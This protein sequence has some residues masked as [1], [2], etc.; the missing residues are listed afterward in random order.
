LS[1]LIV[2][3][4]PLFPPIAIGL[5]FVALFALRPPRNGKVV[6]IDEFARLSDD[7]VK[8][9]IDQAIEAKQRKDLM[10]AGWLYEQGKLWVKAAE[11]YQEA[12]DDLWA[13]E[14]FRRGGDHRRSGEIYRLG[15]FA[16]EAATTLEQGGHL[17]DAG[18]NYAISGDLPRAARLFEQASRPEEAAELYFRLGMFHQAGKL[19]EKA[20]E[21]GRAADAYER[22]LE[23]LG[24]K[25]LEADIRIARVLEKEGREIATIRFLEAVGEVMAAL[26]T[27]I[28]FSHDDEALRLYREYREIL[29]APLLKGAKEGKLSATVLSDLFDRAG[30][31]V[32]AARMA[33]L[34]GQWRRVAELYEKAGK[35][36]KAAAAWKEAGEIGEAALAFER[37]GRFGRAA[38]LFEE[39]GEPVRALHCY[40]QADLHYEAGLLYER[41]GEPEN[42]ITS[43]QSVL[44]DDSNWRDARLRLGALFAL[45]GRSELALD[46]YEDV[47]S[48]EEPGTSDV[49]SLVVM[50]TLLR[51]R[52][53]YGEAAACFSTIAR[54]DASRE[55]IEAQMQDARLRAEKG[56]QEVPVHFPYEPPA[57]PQPDAGQTFERL[58][59][60]ESMAI[61]G[62]FPTDAPGPSM[63]SLPA[64]VTA[65]PLPHRDVADESGYGSVDTEDR[66][67]DDSQAD[68]VPKDTLVSFEAF[69]DGY[70]DESLADPATSAELES[71][72]GQP[73]ADRVTGASGDSMESDWS[74][75]SPEG[76]GLTQADID[77]P[78]AW[79]A[80]DGEWAIDGDE[81]EM[82]W[83]APGPVGGADPAEEPEAA[84]DPDSDE[85]VSG[86]LDSVEFG[87]ETAPSGSPLESFEVFGI[88]DKRERFFVERFFTFIEVGKGED[89]L[90]GDEEEDGLVLLVAGDAEV[91]AAGGEP[92]RFSAPALLGPELLLKG[93]LPDVRITA[94]ST[95]QCWTLSRAAARR[96]AEKDRDVALRLARALRSA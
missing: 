49:D 85:F 70:S 10:R 22:M 48:R 79:E 52:G 40:R 62:P 27:A 16:L 42:A 23:S 92:K 11:C 59:A 56:G 4:S 84:S 35:A 47:L 60:D 38:E 9:L 81:E 75:P 58:P 82:D 36:D 19:F 64:G 57:P 83:A 51:E 66:A 50:A 69:I 55:G 91:R 74:A 2:L 67:W 28:R 14:L 25:T 26:R 18:V 39:R 68:L 15:G 94:A 53:R 32:P 41:V 88:F 3:Q 20:G 46:T 34:L 6:E 72:S 8:R 76:M 73:S 13:A 24:R 93:E 90:Q 61:D 78:P 63:G 77:S 44:P 37:A 96:L 87:G 7:E 65:H 5:F 29:A 71:Q 17:G 95:M 33:R 30:D 80:E 43:Y 54:L 21:R 12:G 86:V 89:V 31:H 45:H 1:L